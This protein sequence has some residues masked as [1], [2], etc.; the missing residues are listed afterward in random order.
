MHFNSTPCTP[1]ATVRAPQTLSFPTPSV[2][3]CSLAN[4]PISSTLA[5]QS[6][7]HTHSL[8]CSNLSHRFALGIT[9]SPSSSSYIL[10]FEFIISSSF[11][12]HLATSILMK[13]QPLE[14]QLLGFLRDKLSIFLNAFALSKTFYWWNYTCIPIEIGM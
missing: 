7:F 6:F 3:G 13:T 11:H 14:L 8:T 2:A 5:T 1:R 9:N 10:Y 12:I 4:H